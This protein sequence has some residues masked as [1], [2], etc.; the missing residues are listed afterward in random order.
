M[1]KI[2]ALF[3]ALCMLVGLMSV[4]SAEVTKLTAWTFIAQHQ[5]YY[6]SMAAKWNELHPDEQI[7][8]EVTTLGYDDMHNK[9]K[10][11]LQ[12]DQGAPDACDVELGQFPNI[13]AFS[14]KLVELSPYIEPYKDDIVEARLQI[15]SKDGGYYGMPLHV[16]AMVAFYRVDL[17]EKAGVDYT[18]IKTW[19]DW[20]EAGLKVKEATG[21]MMGTVETS[22]HWV[23]NLMLGQLGTDI[24]DGENVLVNTPEMAKVIDTQKKWI[25]D[26]ICQVCPGGQPDTEEGKAYIANND[27]ASI[28]MPFWFMSRFTGE[29]GEARANQYVVAPCPVFEEGQIRSVGAGGTGTVIYKNGTNADL[30]ARFFTYAKISEDGNRFVWEILGFDPVNK[31][32][33]EDEALMKNDDNAFNKY[34]I[35]YPVDA[36]L[37]IKDEIGAM[38]SNGISPTIN[39]YVDTTLWNEVYVDGVDTAEALE[40]AQDSIESDLF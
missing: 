15:Y 3:L 18:A 5:D 22:A 27:I 31:A 34:F 35:G 17:L 20:Y 4:A 26:G 39:N 6:E 11:A 2:A 13:L 40:A 28:V 30:A 12:S 16:G 38:I 1:K 37:Q 19:D 29:I 7:E 21:A 23:T 33:W 32:V 8:I 36:L 10:V 14:E 9:M 24:Q 25:A